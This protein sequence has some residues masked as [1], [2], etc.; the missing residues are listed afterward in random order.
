MKWV[1]FPSSCFISKS[2]MCDKLLGAIVVQ[3]E[4]KAWKK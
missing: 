1:A 2:P 4:W 3:L